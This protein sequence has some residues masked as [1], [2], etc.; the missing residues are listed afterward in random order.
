MKLFAFFFSQQKNSYEIGDLNPEKHDEY[1]KI[2]SDLILPY[3]QFHGEKIKK[4]KK[5][6]IKKGIAYLDAVTKID[7]ENWSAYWIKGKGF[8]ALGFSESAYK[9]FRLSFELQK[10]DVDVAKELMIECLRLGKGEEGVKVAKHALSLDKENSGLNANLAF[11]YLIA[12]DLKNATMFVDKAIRI[13]K[14]DQINQDLRTFI[15]D[16]K[17]G[18]KTQPKK[19]D[20]LF[21]Q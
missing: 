11:S 7:P 9:E 10:Q 8:Q 13:D 19:Y 16:V 15:S 5:Q 14:N 18:A 20:D 1:Y 4:P 17:S 21:D 6:N 12:G 2:G 3:R